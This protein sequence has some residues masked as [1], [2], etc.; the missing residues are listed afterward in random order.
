MSH[1]LEK[2]P[3]SGGF[4]GVVSVAEHRVELA[5]VSL[6]AERRR[7][8]EPFGGSSAFFWRVLRRPE[9]LAAGCA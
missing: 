6:F 1:A 3:R 9:E 8:V 5:S 4:P 2:S 7:Y